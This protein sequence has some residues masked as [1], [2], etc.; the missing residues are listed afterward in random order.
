MKK[1]I[2]GTRYY[3]EPYHKSDSLPVL[4]MLHGFLGSSGSFFHLTDALA[5]IA[6]V[7][8]IDLIGHGETESPA[9]PERYSPGE[10]TSDLK[11]ILGSFTHSPVILHGYSMGGRLALMFARRHPQLLKGL[12]LESTTAG[13]PDQ[14][15]RAK[16]K[17]LDR[18]RAMQILEDKERFI[19]EWNRSAIF[20]NKFA[21]P[22][23][24]QQQLEAIQQAQNS[25]GLQNSLLGFGTGAMP[26]LHEYLDDI[27]LPT[28]ILSGDH[29]SK[30]TEEGRK[31]S[32]R[33][34]NSTHTEISDS[35]HRIHLDNPEAYLAAIREFIL[36]LV[37]QPD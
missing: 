19:N 26:A 15:E 16:R 33:I 34:P 17:K 18:K 20:Q 25:I 1:V 37:D 24:L 32:E 28:L 2:R 27:L 12:I 35:S 22:T 7:V 30:F 31:L 4:V 29:D 36:K 23:D 11:E 13:I 5:N 8:L 9:E 21:M 3:I 10:Q 14:G 6:N